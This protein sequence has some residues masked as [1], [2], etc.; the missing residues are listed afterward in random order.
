MRFKDYLAEEEAAR[1]RT[2][3]EAEQ[4]WEL[5]NKHCKDALK[6][7]E[8]PIVRG[9]KGFDRGFGVIHGEAGGRMSRNTTNHYTVILDAVLPKEYPK[10]SASIICANWDNRHHAMGYG[11]KLFAVI[12]FDGVKIAVCPDSD[13]WDTQITIGKESDSI[14]DW[15][16]NLRGVG[17]HDKMSF[18]EMM[19]KLE[20]QRADTLPTASWI[21]DIDHDKKIK[22]VFEAAYTKPFKLTTSAEAIYN[23][24]AVHELWIG[25]KCVAISMKVYKNM[26]KNPDHDAEGYNE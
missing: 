9:M 20:R 18:D 19:A 4:A 7:I 26:M 23:D 5:L 2:E 3:L 11:G 21:D 1:Y 10:R 14:E 24:G 6:D 8:T 25:G 15:N 13:I 22:D 17:I 12:P 16:M